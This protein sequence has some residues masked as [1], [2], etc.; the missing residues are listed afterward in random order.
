MTF[1]PGEEAFEQAVSEGRLSFDKEN[2]HYAGLYMYMGTV[3][4]RDLFKNINTRQYDV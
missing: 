4:G 1:K 3:D 2:Q